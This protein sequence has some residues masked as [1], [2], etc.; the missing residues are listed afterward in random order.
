MNEVGACGDVINVHKDLR[1]TK[2]LHQAVM[3]PTSGG[4]GI[5]TPIANEY[6]G[7]RTSHMI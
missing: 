3:Q 4:N 6:S 2:C 1:L 7:I 5:L